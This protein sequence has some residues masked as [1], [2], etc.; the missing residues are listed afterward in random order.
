[1]NQARV[2]SLSGRSKSGVPA[3]D[4]NV[5]LVT[6][7]LRP[8]NAVRVATAQETGT[9]SLTLQPPAEPKRLVVPVK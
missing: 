9:L 6:L 3:A 2:A 7:A 4:R 8:E 1:L 5:A